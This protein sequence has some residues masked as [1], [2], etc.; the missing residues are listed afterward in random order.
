MPSISWAAWACSVCSPSTPPSFGGYELMV[1]AVIYIA[2]TAVV[3]AYM[4]AALLRPED[5]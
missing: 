4:L 5:F 3:A 1:V 2:A